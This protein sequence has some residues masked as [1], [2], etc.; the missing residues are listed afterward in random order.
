MFGLV[1]K[2]ILKLSLNEITN[3]CFH[4]HAVHMSFLIHN[5]NKEKYRTKSNDIEDSVQ[6]PF[7]S[8]SGLLFLSRRTDSR[9]NSERIGTKSEEKEVRTYWHKVRRKKKEK[10]DRNSKM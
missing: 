8:D 9:T 7:K 2:I 3:D 4:R 1:V 10:I 5:K 6:D